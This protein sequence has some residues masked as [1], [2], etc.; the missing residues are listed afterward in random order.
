MTV[1]ALLTM[2]YFLMAAGKAQSHP[3]WSWVMNNI[4][5]VLAGVMVLGVLA[6][7]WNLMNSMVDY[8]KNQ[9]LHEQGIDPV[10]ATDNQEPSFFSKMY[11]KAWSLVPIEKEADI[12]LDHDYDGIHELDNRLPPWWLWTFYITII[13]GVGYL[14][15]YHMSDIGLSQQEEY[16]VAMKKGEDQ[17]ATFAARQVNSI[18]EKNMI[19]YTD[20][21]SLSTGHDIFIANCAACHGKLGEGG[22]GPNMTD[23]NWIHGGSI[24]NVYQTIKNGVPEKGMIAWKSQLQPATM[25]KVASYIKTLAGTNPPNQKKAEGPIYEEEIAVNEELSETGE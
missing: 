22:V 5:V 24:A 15:V 21:K 1:A 14:Y 8:Q 6:T 3:A 10:G 23:K 13:A 4:I 25:L 18:D 12:Q 20:A 17:K 19:A 16:E 2:P 7:L 9:I 11:D